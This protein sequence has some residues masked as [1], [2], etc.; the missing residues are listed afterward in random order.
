MDDPIRQQPLQRNMSAA[1]VAAVAAVAGAG[2]AIYGATQA[3]SAQDSANAT[4]AA[5]VA[6]NN[7][8]NWQNYLMER[9]INPDGA[10]AGTIPTNPQAV[11]AKLPLYANVN[12]SNGIPAGATRWAKAGTPAP[13][14]NMTLAT[15]AAP[16]PAAA[17]AS[18]M[19]SLYG[20]N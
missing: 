16:A 10:A 2:T 12:V 17:P 11:N 8:A 9:G 18:N 7:N 19:M 14:T 1:T 6:A 15:S 4:N 3:G 20:M 5:S 13:A